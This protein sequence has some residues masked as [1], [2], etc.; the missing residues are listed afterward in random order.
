MLAAWAARRADYASPAARRERL[1]RERTE[2]ER[3]ANRADRQTMRIAL[4]VERDARATLNTAYRGGARRA[5]DTR[6]AIHH[7]Q[8][9]QRTGEATLSRAERHRAKQAARAAR[10]AGDPPD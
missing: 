2:R 10:K 1:L 5:L 6:E 3:E 7:G 8:A 4:P 9:G